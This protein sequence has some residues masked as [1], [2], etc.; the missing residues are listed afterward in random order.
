MI[1]TNDNDRR[2]IRLRDEQCVCI[3]YERAGYR[4]FNEIIQKD[5]Q[6]YRKF[7]SN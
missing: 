3:K 4:D 2:G 1:K 7:Q 5:N 6:S